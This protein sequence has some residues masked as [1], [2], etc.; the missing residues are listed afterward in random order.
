MAFLVDPF[1]QSEKETA[2]HWLNED[3]EASLLLSRD[4]KW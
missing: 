1:C 2:Y 3:G 4:G